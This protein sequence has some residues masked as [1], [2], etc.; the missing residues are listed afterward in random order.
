[1]LTQRAGWTGLTVGGCAGLAEYEDRPKPPL[2]LARYAMS[3]A[4]LALYLLFIWL[5]L[6]APH[7]YYGTLLAW[8]AMPNADPFGDLRSI[9]LSGACWRA[10]VN[11]YAPSPCMGA[12]VFN[13]A[14][15]LLR[16]ALLPIGPADTVP[17]GLA[18]G[19][20]FLAAVSLLPVPESW[21]E[22]GLRVAAMASGMV[23]Y[24]LESANFDVVIF[25]G[26]LGAVLL[27][28]RGLGL[29][30]LGYAV[31]LLAAALKFY[32]AALLALVIRERPRLVA[33]VGA[34]T[35]LAAGGYFLCFAHATAA[36][37]SIIPA[38]LPFRCLFGAMNLPFGLLLLRYMPVLT[39]EPSSQDFFAAVN[40]PVAAE[41][42]SFMPRLL[43]LF[44]VFAAFRAAPRY[45]PDISRLDDARLVFFLAGAILIV[46]CFC[47]VQN[48]DYRGIFLLFLLPGL[49]RM[50][51]VTQHRRVMLLPWL[52]LAL[53]WEAL[54]RGL[55]TDIGL[56]LLGRAHVVDAQIVFFLAREGLWWWVIIQL[57]ACLVCF[58]RDAVLAW[59]GYVSGGQSATDMRTV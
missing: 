34:M 22:L 23:V 57:G 50:A 41:I 15:L 53:L 46:F 9:L 59:T 26:L 28:R 7:A 27:L 6:F 49:W 17:G 32:P 19:A 1:M 40:H 8:D 16:A 30:L 3:G 11:V 36:A 44:A 51:A 55:S 24:A 52:V 48:L 2:W 33:A 56:L 54:F 18:L 43:V 4:G 37:V 45:A 35:M 42:L 47:A 20:L 10:G 38:G 39:I 58:G 31:I 21:G 29:R 25:V 14:P 5:R 13:Y 12:G